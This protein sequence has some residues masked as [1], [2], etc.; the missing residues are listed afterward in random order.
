MTTYTKG[1][2]VMTPQGSGSVVYVRNMGPEFRD[3]EAVSVCLDLKAEQWGLAYRGT[4]FDPKDVNPIDATLPCADVRRGDPVRTPLGKGIFRY[5]RPVEAGSS[6]M[7][8]A[9]T[10]DQERDAQNALFDPRDVEPI[11]SKE[12]AP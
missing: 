2:R 5:L 9:V 7:W 12:G 8:A 11:D 3:A 6:Y 10:I 4:V 1:Q